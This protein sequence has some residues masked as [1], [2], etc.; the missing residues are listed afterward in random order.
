M[1]ALAGHPFQLIVGDCDSNDGS[2]NMLQR[3]ERAGA[4]TLQ[5][6]RG[7]RRHGEWLDLWLKT[8]TSTYV[9]FCDSDVEFLRPNWLAEMVQA[10]EVS[11][12]T[13]V[14]TRIQA[15]DGVA[16]THPAT[17][18]AAT[19]AAR[20]EPWLMLIRTEPSQQLNASF[21]YEERVQSDGSKIAYDTAAAFFRELELAG[22][23]FVE[24]P[25]KFARSFRHYSGMTWQGRGIPLRR[26]LKQIAKRMTVWIRWQRSKVAHRSATQLTK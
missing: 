23:T 21:L 16:Y 12:A 20:P 5:I 22:L 7:G 6:A 9:V 14:A 10:A 26:Q 1:H 19:L 18:A 11:G 2:I 13:L 25:A 3:Y 8:A 24:M 4:C 17:G 15:R